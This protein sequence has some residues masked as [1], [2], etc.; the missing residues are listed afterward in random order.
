MAWRMWQKDRQADPRVFLPAIKAW[1]KDGMKYIWRSD[2][3]DELY[4]LRKDAKEQNNL[5]GRMPDK[6]RQMRLELEDY[7]SRL[8]PGDTGDLI[9]PDRHCPPELLARLRGMGWYL[10]V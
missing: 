10:A 5:I 9:A 1:R 6:A 7:L 4:D 8:P 2:L 3:R